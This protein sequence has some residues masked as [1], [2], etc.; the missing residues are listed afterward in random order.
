MQYVFETIQH[1]IEVPE[2]EPK[3]TIGFPT[4]HAGA[5]R[6]AENDSDENTPDVLMFGSFTGFLSDCSQIRRNRKLA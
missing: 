4:D 6:Q 2:P 5:W 1:L 3:H